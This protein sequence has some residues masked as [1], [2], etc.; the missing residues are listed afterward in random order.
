MDVIE[1]RDVPG[2][3]GD[4]RRS[5]AILSPAIAGILGTLLLHALLLPSL[6]VGTQGQAG[7][8]PESMEGPRLASS[9]AESLLLISIETNGAG[10]GQVQ[11]AASTLPTLSKMKLRPVIDKESIPVLDVETL[12]L[13]EDQAAASVSDDD[14]QAQKAHLLGI[15][16]G[17]I[18]A[19]IDRIWRRP[20]SPVN[21]AD[22]VTEDS[23][24]CE[25]QIIQAS[26]G[27]VQEILLPRCNGSPAW[28]RSLVLAIQQASPLP[29]PPDPSVFRTSV[30]LDF[31]GLQ[32]VAGA[33]ED[34]YEYPTESF[35]RS[36]EVD[37]Q[38][39][40]MKSQSGIDGH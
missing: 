34:D 19:R 29:A 18:Q 8:V 10:R 23:F 38:V 32:Y 15:Y 13:G 21:G 3:K 40:A 9:S 39:A 2:A 4:G 20:R 5:P 35:P 27:A 37:R 33:T 7:R 28:Q 6:Y 25:A 1:W 36:S 31:T 17:Q 22:A 26:N 30:T 11:N 12:T 14:R 24:R 16:T